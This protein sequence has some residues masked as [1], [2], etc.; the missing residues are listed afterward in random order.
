MQVVT[1]SV[2]SRRRRWTLHHSK[3][4]CASRNTSRRSLR[5]TS[6]HIHF[7]CNATCAYASTDHSHYP[8]I[9]LQGV[10]SFVG[11]SASMAKSKCDYVFHAECAQGCGSEDFDGFSRQCKTKGHRQRADGC[12]WD[13]IDSY[14]VRFPTTQI[15]KELMD[16]SADTL[17]PVRKSVM[18]SLQ[19]AVQKSMMDPRQLHRIHS[20]S[21]RPAQS[22]TKTGQQASHS[23]QWSD[24]ALLYFTFV[25]DKALPDGFLR[26][27]LRLTPRSQQ[28]HRGK[29]HSW[30]HRRPGGSVV[31]H[32]D[33]ERRKA[34]S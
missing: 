15:Q 31:L 21:P 25:A 14:H 3:T 13:R 10:D 24:G 26:D 28:L 29:Q 5:S 33:A 19:H 34:Q 16:T 4:H 30:P 17:I 2:W 11:F 1:S 7:Y 20:H 23:Q 12:I 6:Y 9:T 22:F 8:R 18:S 27:F 32:H